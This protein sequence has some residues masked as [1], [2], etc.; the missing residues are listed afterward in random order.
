MKCSNSTMKNVLIIFCLTLFS[1]LLAA[2]GISDNHFAVVNKEEI[3]AQTFFDEF[4]KGIRETF[5]HGKITDKELENFRQKVVKNLINEKLL[6]Q[7]A[8][9]QGIKPRPK[10]VA[11]KIEKETKDFRKQKNL[12]HHDGEFFS[13]NHLKCYGKI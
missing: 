7:L 5:Y 6:L 1:P 4:Q 2:A 11:K 9:K 12:T 13:G 10:N 3:L 8:K